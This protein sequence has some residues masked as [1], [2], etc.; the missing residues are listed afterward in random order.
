MAVQWWNWPHD[1]IA[2]NAVLLSN[3][4]DED[5][6]KKMELLSYELDL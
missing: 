2:E 5:T 3:D 4:I 6:L 1:V